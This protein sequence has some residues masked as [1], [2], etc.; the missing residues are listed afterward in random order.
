MQK[1]IFTINKMIKN[2]IVGSWKARRDGRI[3]ANAYVL[4]T[5]ILTL[6]SDGR[7]FRQFDTTKVVVR[8]D[9]GKENYR[10]VVTQVGNYTLNGNV[11]RFSDMAPRYETS[12]YFINTDD[13]SPETKQML[14]SPMAIQAGEASLK[15]AVAEVMKNKAQECQQDNSGSMPTCYVR[16]EDNRLIMSFEG[17]DGEDILEKCEEP[18]NLD[19]TAPATPVEEALSST[20]DS[21]MAALRAGDCTYLNN[22]SLYMPCII[23]EKGDQTYVTIDPLVV[24]GMELI[25]VFTDKDTMSQSELRQAKTEYRL[26]NMNDLYAQM[27]V[28]DGI[29]LNPVNGNSVCLKKYMVEAMATYK[30]GGVGSDGRIII[31]D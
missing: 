22:Y 21:F 14:E 4:C 12:E 3:S 19:R 16:V 17:Y 5:D 11:I 1:V 25:V 28:F 7:T 18:A 20:A 27:Q 26:V 2:S 23:E 30:W 31:N 6:D 15:G 29:C 10:V 13:C 9:G 8:A 24:G